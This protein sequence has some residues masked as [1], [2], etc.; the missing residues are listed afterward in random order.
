MTNSALDTFASACYG[1]GYGWGVFHTIFFVVHS[2]LWIAAAISI[3]RNDRLTGGGKFVWFAVITGF[4]FLGSL[5][6]FFFGRKAQL[7]KTLATSSSGT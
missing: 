4:P 6:W 3:L 1:C 7:V 2:I 5:G